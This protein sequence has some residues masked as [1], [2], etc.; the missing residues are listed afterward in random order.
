VSGEDISRQQQRV[1]LYMKLKWFGD[2]CCRVFLLKTLPVEPQRITQEII[3]LSRMEDL[4][5]SKAR[6][7]I[8]KLKDIVRRRKELERLI[9]PPGN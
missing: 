7:Y 4:Y 8:G 1:Y 5:R 6:F 3:Y 2:F 9:T